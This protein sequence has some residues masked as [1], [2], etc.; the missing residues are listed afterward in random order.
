MRAP[1]TLRA[2]LTIGPTAVVLTAC[3]GGDGGG[4]PFAP[5]AWRAC[6][7]L[8]DAQR[9]LGATLR[10]GLLGR[11]STVAARL[12]A[13]TH[14]LRRGTLPAGAGREK[15]R[16]LVRALD[17]MSTAVGALEHTLAAMRTDDPTDTVAV[18][19]RQADVQRRALAIRADYRAVDG[20]ARRAGLRGC[21]HPPPGGEVTA[22]ASTSDTFTAGWRASPAP[23]GPVPRSGRPRPL[24]GGFTAGRTVLAQA[25]CLA[26]HRLGVDGNRG[27]GPDLSHVGARLTAAQLERALLR[28]AAPMP[29]FSTL[30]RRDPRRFRALLAFLQ[31]QR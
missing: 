4:G 18:G 24:H 12:R 31:A 5:Q 16:R 2:S 11:R 3:G 22:T 20:A 23:L 21:G 15:A 8:P 25:G 26:C 13:A 17:A 27:P 28:P 29:S 30:R 1:R 10:A 6:A 7:G 14:D 9:L 19:H